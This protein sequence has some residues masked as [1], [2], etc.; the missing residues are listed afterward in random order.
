MSIRK[1]T[2]QLTIEI[3]GKKAEGTYND[4][5]KKSRNLNKELRGLTPGTDAFI[6]KSAEL[7]KV[8]SKLADIRTQTRGVAKGMQDAQKKTG[9]F[10]KG[11]KLAL[12]AFSAAA[13]IGGIKRIG[14]SIIG[15]AT[16]SLKLYDLQAKADA[17]LKAVITSTNG[18]AGRSF[19]QLKKQASDLQNIT[20]FGDEETQKAQAA[21]LTFTKVQGD[22]FDETL[23][24]ILDMS[25]AL[26]KNLQ[27]SSLQVGKALND[28]ILGVSAL[29]EAGVQFTQKQKDMI[30]SLVE[31]GDAAAAQRIM[32][33]ELETQFGGSAEAAAKAGLGP[34]QQF[35]N[36]IGD[37]KESIG[38]LVERGLKFM[39]PYFNLGVQFLEK[40]VR[41]VTSGDAATGRFGGT[42]NFIIGLFKITIKYYG[43]LYDG[44]M[45][46]V[47]GVSTFI[48]KAME[49]KLINLYI[50]NFIIKP[51]KAA[52]KFIS[53]F[54]AS[55]AG[56]QAAAR[57]AL[58][59]VKQ[60]L[61]STVLSLKIFA[62]QADLAL[63]IRSSTRD[64][65][66]REIEELKQLKQTA[67]EAGKTIGEAYRDAYD[68]QVAQ[69]STDSA[70]P[71][72]GNAPGVP[73]GPAP[74]SSVLNA[75][76]TASKPSPAA[77]ARVKYEGSILD[78]MLSMG[79]KHYEQQDALLVA[80]HKKEQQE[81][82]AQF[83]RGELTGAE[84]EIK[85][86]EQQI[87]SHEARL[88]L[89]QELG[90]LDNEQYRAVQ[91]E[92]L[93]A[94]KEINDLKLAADKDLAEKQLEIAK[95]KADQEKQIQQDTLQATQ[96][97]LSVGIE[98]LARN[99]ASKKKNA[100]AIKAFEIARIGANL[101]SEISGYFKTYSGI[102]G[103]QIIAGVLSGVATGRALIATNKIRK[104]KF[105]LGGDTGPG[106]AYDETG[107]RAAGIVHDN[108][109]VIP[110]WMRL[111]ARMAPTIASIESIRRRGSF[112]E[113][114]DVNTTPV[115][116]SD[117]P[118]N[119]PG[120][121][122]TDPALVSVL[123]EVAD[124]A[125]TL[126]NIKAYVNYFDLEQASSEIN[127]IER[128]V[129]I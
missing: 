45:F 129:N 118:L 104:Q 77:S 79:K 107:H 101:S 60:G 3:N 103:G 23:P 78:L 16:D 108:E 12:G 30:K 19:E 57:Q 88:L 67:S 121:A 122:A 47:N 11:F 84:Y 24:I 125:K 117:V 76:P 89:M 102:P 114:G 94:K 2:A 105:Y 99:E 18:I 124:A 29:G 31:G 69:S 26:G 14:Q 51:V 75:A 9:L 10:A 36:R 66:K 127:D 112:M 106:Y 123:R 72:G 116:V 85:R 7:K 22:V 64:R 61:A 65:L 39:I 28:P 33:K 55:W 87:A 6:K 59:N 38:L 8:N 50:N 34:Y 98:L 35:Q 62:K 52:F 15:L 96:G 1:D 17:Q 48:S 113:G 95:K 92:Q 100:A 46:M 71:S 63:S 21:L 68:A 86:R 70:T 20:L 5:L 25:A 54:T 82:E 27:E 40:F 73:A 41:A 109:Y 111:D 110:K 13:V 49:L 120:G 56:L 93:L 128:L 43:L 32:L 115:G 91:N 37:I 126:K 97:F 74:S 83:L 80:A 44:L 4:L 119:V 58:D 90:L 42:I 53:N 81:L